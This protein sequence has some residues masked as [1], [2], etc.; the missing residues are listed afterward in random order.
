[1]YRSIFICI[2]VLPVSSIQF[3]YIFLTE[4]VLL[5]QL[6]YAQ[7]RSSIELIISEE[8]I[9]KKDYIPNYYRFLFKQDM[10]II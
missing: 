4:A 9:L 3:L 1:M 2:I 10:I 8:K 5:T 6:R 7:L